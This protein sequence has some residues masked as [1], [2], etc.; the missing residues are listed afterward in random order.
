MILLFD[1]QKAYLCNMK[2]YIVNGIDSFDETL[3]ENCLSFFPQWRKDKM[4]NYKFLKGRIQCALAYLL[5]IHALREEGVF[6]EMPEFFYGEHQKPFLKNYPGWH[7]NLS[8]CKNAVC[9]VLSR[10]EVGIDI[11]EIKEY[12]E[13]LAE[14]I[15]NEQELNLLHCSD[16]QADEFY[17]LWTRKEAVF[18]KFG[19][20]ITKD[21]KNV[22]NNNVVIDSY[23]LGD[24]WLSVSYDK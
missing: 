23:R 24:I 4:L 11:E 22:L 3:I 7:F 9:C 1:S 21:I 12:K 2:I 6:D 5:L 20:G 15:C 10:K 17:K 19:S 14:Y 16:N 18:K 13:S 8:H